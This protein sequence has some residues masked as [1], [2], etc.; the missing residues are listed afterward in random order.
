MSMCVHMKARGQHWVSS[1]ITTYLN[2]CD[3]AVSVTESETLQFTC[4]SW[5]SSAMTGAMLGFYMGARDLA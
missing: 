3:S 4:S 2:F 5:N 1:F